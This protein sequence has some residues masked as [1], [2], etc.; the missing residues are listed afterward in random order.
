MSI[1]N[2]LVSYWKLDEIS[3]D[4][5][6][7]SYGNINGVSSGVTISQFGKINHSC[8]FSG[9]TNIDFG[10]PQDL[11][12]ESGGTIS[13]WFF[14]N[15]NDSHVLISKGNYTTDRNGFVC[16][17]YSSQPGYLS[18]GL[19]LANSS[20]YVLAGYGIIDFNDSWAFYTATWDG[21]YLTCYINGVAGNPAEQTL[22][23]S[24]NVN[25]LTFG[26]DNVTISRAY[27]YFNGLIDE[28]AIWNRALT[29]EEITEVYN[30]GLSGQTLI[31]D[32]SRYINGIDGYSGEHPISDNNE[33]NETLIGWKNLQVLMRKSTNAGTSFS[34]PIV[35]THSI[36]SPAWEYYYYGTVLS[37]NGD[38]H[39]VPNNAEFG[40]K[41][42]CYTGI[43]STYSLAYTTEN[44]YMGGVLDSYGYIHFVP[45]KASV[46]QKI[47]PS[48]VV[49]T[50]SLAFTYGDN[51]AYNGGVLAPNGDIHFV[52]YA[53]W[54]DGVGIGQKISKE[55]I[56]S[57]YA[58]PSA[59]ISVGGVLSPNGTI[60]LAPFGSNNMGIKIN[61]TNDTVSTY[62]LIYTTTDAYS[63]CV[64]DSHGNVHFVPNNA[65]VGQ[66]VDINGIVSTYSLI[67][68][69]DYAYNFGVLTPNGDVHFIS[70]NGKDSQRIDKNNIVSTYPKAYGYNIG[71]TLT[72]NGDIYCVSY[73][74]FYEKVSTLPAIPFDISLCISPFFNKR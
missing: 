12:S 61:T 18:V 54:D 44:A 41:I 65:E 2:G 63:G 21:N 23:P 15:D 52:K 22:I 67:I 43:V 48:G 26:K 35:S 53:A 20:S 3:G 37:P 70:S 59:E 46:G 74:S 13:A 7:D 64:L 58:Y 6:Y 24:V 72:P 11:V 56:A 4:Q 25:N 33:I 16:S 47:S 31:T 66:K 28:V 32:K 29:Q 1:L 40:Q 27:D 5:V 8:L 36:L 68:T 55:G 69:G 38:I 19:E 10:N 30:K 62:S 14:L 50:Y 17:V 39:C 49:S 71:A 57:T 42:N 34:K 60:Y 73:S 9:G 51:E 45:A